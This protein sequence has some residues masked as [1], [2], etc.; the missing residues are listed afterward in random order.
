MNGFTGAVTLSTQ[1]LPTGATATFSPATLSATGSAVLTVS[2]SSSTPPDGYTLSVVGT[3]GGVTEA[4]S[5]VLFVQTPSTAG[6]QVPLT[7]FFNRPGIVNDGTT[8]STG[9]DGDGNAYSAKL[10]GKFEN[11]NNLEFTFGT[12]NTNNVISGGGTIPLPAG[13]YSTLSILAAAVNS[14]QLSQVFTVTYSDGTTST[15]TQSLSNWATTSANQTGET[16]V[17]A[18]S[19]RDHW[20]GTMTLGTFSLFGYSFTLN[21]AK[22]VSSIT[23]PAN[24][25]VIVAAITLLPAS[26]TMQVSLNSYYNREGIVTDESL[27]ETG[28]LDNDGN[29]YSSNLLGPS[30]TFNGSTFTLGPANALDVISC[31]SNV[32]TISPSSYHTL[33]MLATGVNAGVQKSQT[34]TVTY[35]DGSTSV[36][37]QSLSNWVGTSNQVG[38]TTVIS[39]PYRDVWNGSEY[40]TTVKVYGYTFALNPSKSASSITL[41]NNANVEVLGLGLIM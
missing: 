41:P 32:I 36:F 8:F 24:K 22:T 17:A 26:T 28:G 12:P 27:F 33:N 11:Y 40:T 2:T 6:V 25:N 37:T 13:T 38:E 5:P 35:T 20:N 39:M 29:A 19:Y 34:F 18:M 9:A 15:F 31:S 1:G 23:L 7:S 21:S 10:L 14:A 4:A 16:T 30:L 3:S